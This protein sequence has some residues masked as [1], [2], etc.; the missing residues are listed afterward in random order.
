MKEGSKEEDQK[1]A[2]I[3]IYFRQG[4]DAKELDTYLP[5]WMIVMFS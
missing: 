3:I 2:D 1:V 5:S 4:P